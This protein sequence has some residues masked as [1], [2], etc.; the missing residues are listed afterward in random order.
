MWSEAFDRSGWVAVLVGVL[1][2]GC[3]EPADIDD[4]AGSGDSDFGDPEPGDTDEPGTGGD[5]EDLA[6]FC[7]REPAMARHVRLLALREH[8]FDDRMVRF[9]A[10]YAEV[11]V[12]EDE[13]GRINLRSWFAGPITAE[14]G[15]LS[16]QGPSVEDLPLPQL[17]VL[18]TSPFEDDSVSRSFDAVFS[19][20]VGGEV[21][22]STC[23]EVR[24][25]NMGTALNAGADYG[26][27]IGGGSLCN[28]P[29]CGIVSDPAFA[30]LALPHAIDEQLVVHERDEDGRLTNPYASPHIPV[31]LVEG[32]EAGGVRRVRELDSRCNASGILCEDDVH[33]SSVSSLPT[34]SVGMFEAHRLEDG[35]DTFAYSQADCALVYEERLLGMFDDVTTN[36]S[37]VAY[38][39]IE[40]LEISPLQAQASDL[41][42]PTGWTTC[43]DLPM[44]HTPIV[45][46]DAV[47]VALPDDIADFRERLQAALDAVERPS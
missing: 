44:G 5:D 42:A 46:A 45:G 24:G 6:L 38:E 32:A 18:E 43:A 35:P 34:A 29:L 40:V 13:D 39:T 21:P 37:F 26:R 16:A 11:D 36:E 25:H 4:G 27:R 23:F 7:E 8:R 12:V 17:L 15:E 28:A 31:S 41:A 9:V 2:S 47:S 10:G 19:V 33:P 20:A 30:G 22:A 14:A 1:A 3:G